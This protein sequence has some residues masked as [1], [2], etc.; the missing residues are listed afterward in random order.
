MS[1]T[2]ITVERVNSVERHPDA[3]RLE[4]VQVLGYKVITQKGKFKIGDAAIY[5][6][7]DILIPEKVADEFQV[8]NYL[9]HSLYPGDD[10]KTQCRVSSARIRGIPSHGFVVGPVENDGTFGTDL[11]QRYGGHKYEPPKRLGAGDTVAGNPFFHKYTN[12]ENIQRWNHF[13][14]NE[15]VRITEKIHGTNCRVGIIREGEQWVYAAGSH[16]LRRD[17][18]SMYWE[19]MTDDMIGMLNVLC[20][21]EFNVIVFGEIF[22]PGIQT[23]DYGQAEVRFQVFD[24]TKDGVYQDWEAVRS[25]CSA[26]RILTVPLLYEGPYSDAIVDQYTDGPTVLAPKG[27]IKCPFKG[28]EGIVITP[29]VERVVRNDRVIAKSV[30]A[31][32]RDKQSWQEMGE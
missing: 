1:K 10:L 19:P 23:M 27:Q 29:L 20:D 26:W 21:G 18:P 6:P 16:N 28:R 32:Y 3:D 11:T 17:Q 5:F 14:E 25:I 7:P 30:S 22:G 2:I 13:E 15:Q 9:K 8:K 4:I 31:D 24:I 12:I